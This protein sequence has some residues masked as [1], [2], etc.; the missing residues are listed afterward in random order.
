ML[1]FPSPATLYLLG[2][3][4]TCGAGFPPSVQSVILSLYVQQGG[5]EIG[6]IFG[7]LGVIQTMWCVAPR[8]IQIAFL[9]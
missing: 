7:A 5:Q 9:N 3:V 8:L 4:G 2:V 6:K 1:L